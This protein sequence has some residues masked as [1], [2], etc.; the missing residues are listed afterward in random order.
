MLYNMEMCDIG[1]NIA[2]YMLLCTIPA[3]LPAIH[4]FMLGFIHLSPGKCLTVM[5]SPLL[6]SQNVLS[7]PS[8]SVALPL[9]PCRLRD[10]SR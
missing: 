10:H 6:F 1:C 7:H 8:T 2:I 3:C 9:R 4:P 5:A